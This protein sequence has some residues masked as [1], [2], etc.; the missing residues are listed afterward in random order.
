MDE[1]AFV[2]IRSAHGTRSLL[3]PVCLKTFDFSPL[4]LWISYHNILLFNR[5]GSGA[6]DGGRRSM[7][8]RRRYWMSWISAMLFILLALWSIPS[9]LRRLELEN[10]RDGNWIQLWRSG[11]MKRILREFHQSSTRVLSAHD[12]LYE[13]DRLFTIWVLKDA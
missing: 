8:S 9:L 10:D 2:I 12:S 6:D 5:M 3:Y 1:G 11:E 7:C 13:L 4:V